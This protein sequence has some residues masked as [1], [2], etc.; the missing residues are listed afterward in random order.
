MKKQL[1][2]SRQY[3]IIVILYT[4]GTGIL[5]IPASIV[6]EVK[7]DAWIVATMGT[8][9]SL[10][11][12]K[13]YIILSNKMANL[14]LVEVFEKFLGSFIGKVISLCFILLTLL[15]SGELLY[16]I[17]NF[18]QTEV[19]PETP[20][21][22]FAI[23]FNFI[24]LFAAYQGLEVFARTLEILFPI[25]LFIFIIFLFFVSPQID[26]KNVQPIFEV[27]IPPLIYSVLH[28][29]G[30]FSFPLIVLLM[31]FPS[32]INNLESGKK[33]FYIGI[34][35]GGFIIT[36]FIALSILVLGVTN[37]TLRT[38]PSYTL[39]QRVSVGNFLQRVEII[40]AFIWM[41][42]IFV[43]AFMYFYASLIGISQMLKLKDHR[44]LILPL[45]MISIALS[46]I[47]HANIIHSDKYNQQ[48]WPLA[49]AVFAIL[50][51][52]ILLITA[53]FRRLKNK[54]VDSAIN[55]DQA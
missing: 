55:N 6:S 39:A 12:I 32:A 30:L 35:V 44:P 17:G 7:Q 34:I 23:L 51:P 10:L 8:L 48:T 5:I 38:F 4:V 43:R 21:V 2:S 1:I 15:S 37:T 47:V 27:S 46:Q 14:T 16:F 41:V 29:M 40:M 36:V 9:L 13:L 20:P 33:G 25:F 45:G 50:L 24:I 28:F 49:I 52:L 53:K 3:T 54:N 31:I 19:M 22:V 11:L 42:T 26:I 18:L